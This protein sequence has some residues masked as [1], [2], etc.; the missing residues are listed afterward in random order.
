MNC[1]VLSFVNSI[2]ELEENNKFNQVTNA[3]RL[4]FVSKQWKEILKQT[5]KFQIFCFTL[6]VCSL[7]SFLI[8]FLFF[9]SIMIK[10]YVAQHEKKVFF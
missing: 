10:V 2:R 8:R 4:S 1:N 7:F 6:K 3:L 9:P 5:L